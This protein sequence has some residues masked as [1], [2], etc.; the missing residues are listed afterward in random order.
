MLSAVDVCICVL[1]YG[2]DKKHFKLAQRVLNKPMQQLAAAG[3]KFC[4]CCNAIG[5]DTR[6][7]LRRLLAA[8]FYSATL[9]DSPL[10]VYKYP[11]MRK[12]FYGA[13]IAEP[14]L[15]WFDHDS[16]LDP[17][18][19][20]NTW[21]IRLRK[22]LAGCNVVGSV[23]RGRINQERGYICY[24]NASWW[25]ANTNSLLQNSWPPDD[26]GQKKGDILF[27]EFIAQHNLTLCHFR[28]G[29]KINVNDVGVEAAAP[30]T[31]VN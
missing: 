7:F 24:P 15:M 23:N 21:L 20:L 30:R 31:I 22:Q 11:M 17:A 5:D 10:N 16:Y 28:D 18:I 19:D 3:A 8:E 29:V 25:A 13:R 9:V 1:F 12:M 27:G 2:A 6:W 26:L 14:L 4:F